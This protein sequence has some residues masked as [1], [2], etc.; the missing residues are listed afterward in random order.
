MD[1]FSHNRL[2]ELRELIKKYNHYYYDL[3]D[4]IVSDFEYDTLYKELESLESQ[5]LGI[6]KGISPLKKIGG[7]VDQ[8]FKKIKHKIPMISLSNSY[9]KEDI[10]AWNEKLKRFLLDFLKKE[11]DPK[12]Y[13]E[14]LSL[15]ENY[16]KN[17]FQKYN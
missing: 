11:K 8:R 6:D 2:L 9:N 12:I 15:Y 4:P 5:E 13:S 14:V 3:S 10:Y 17:F 16:K 7:E 1:L